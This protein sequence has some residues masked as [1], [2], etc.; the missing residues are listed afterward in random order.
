MHLYHW[1]DEKN[2]RYSWDYIIVVRISPE[3]SSFSYIES[4]SIAKVL[5]NTL[6]KTFENFNLACIT[7]QDLG[8]SYHKHIHLQNN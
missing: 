5:V 3:I 1:K 4:V 2:K 8:S 6:K 7:V